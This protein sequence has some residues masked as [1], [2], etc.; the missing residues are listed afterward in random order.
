MNFKTMTMKDR[1]L[2]LVMLLYTLF[3]GAGTK[4]FQDDNPLKNPIGFVISLLLVFYML[5]RLRRVP[6]AGKI[7]G[8]ILIVSIWVLYHWLRVGHYDT[9]FIMLIFHIFTGYLMICL[10]KERIID[11]YEN[12][13]YTFAL[14]GLLMWVV[15]NIISSEVMASFAPFR[16][17]SYN[18][19]FDRSGSFLFYVTGSW[20]GSQFIELYRNQGYC[21]EAGRFASLTSLGFLC[22]IIKN[23]GIA[24]IWDK[25]LWVY[26]LTIFSTFSTTGYITTL[27]ILGLTIFLGKS[28]SFFY[29]ALLGVLLAVAIVYL[30]DA[31]FLGEKIER[32]LDT[33]SFLSHGAEYYSESGVQTVERFEGIYLD[34]LNFRDE[35]LM[36]YGLTDR[37]SYM[38]RNINR[39]LITSNGITK[40]FAQYGIILA[41][42]FFFYLFKGTTGILAS[43]KCFSKY[44]LFIALLSISISY[45][46]NKTPLIFAFALYGII[47]KNKIYDS[48]K[49]EKV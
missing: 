46:F 24:K 26:I 3:L 21:W 25:R 33:S 17:S 27:I 47:N 14:I 43:R 9:A 22:Y 34:W 13:A 23:N 5:K 35:P 10:Y 38:Q 6:N 18:N 40:P 7:I 12:V 2:Y 49:Y 4:M 15:N 41:L 44:L 36:G 29:R 45:D 28:F 42:I 20:K 30:Q 32:Q 48:Y 16:S 39:E 1:G 19:A 31:D 8:I 11:Y 37:W